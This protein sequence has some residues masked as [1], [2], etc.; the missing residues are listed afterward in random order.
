MVLR[1]TEDG[2]WRGVWVKGPNYTLEK[3]FRTI[4]TIFQTEEDAIKSVQRSW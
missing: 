3:P 1:R 4:P 2:T